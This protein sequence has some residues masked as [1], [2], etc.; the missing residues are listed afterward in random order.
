MDK[1]RVPIGCIHT[2]HTPT[3]EEEA[4]SHAIEWHRVTPAEAIFLR[5]YYLAKARALSSTF[6]TVSVAILLAEGVASA[7]GVGGIGR[8]LWVTALLLLV[9]FVAFEAYVHVWQGLDST[10]VCAY[11]PIYRKYRRRFGHYTV[12][13]VDGK[14]HT[15]RLEDPNDRYDR[16]MVVNYRGLS[17]AIHSEVFPD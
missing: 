2:P 13:L 15:Y 12:I 17:C 4:H 7:L 3:P 8:T 10:A 14:K 1:Y 11:V 6:I 16:V 5:T 9:S